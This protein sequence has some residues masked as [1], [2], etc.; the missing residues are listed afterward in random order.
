MISSG[1]PSRRSSELTCRP[2]PALRAS[3]CT[4]TRGIRRGIWVVAPAFMLDLAHEQ[5]NKS[6]ATTAREDAYFGHY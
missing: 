6:D 5:L 4:N 1:W 3:A 2:R